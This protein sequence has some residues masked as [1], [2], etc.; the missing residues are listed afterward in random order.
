MAI[1]DNILGGGG[2]N[3]GGNSDNSSSTNSHDLNTTFGTDP[4]A[5]LNTSNVLHSD[6]QDGGH[7]GGSDDF[8][9]IGNLGVG[10]SAPTV[11]GV[12][13]SNDSSDTS[14]SHDNGGLLGGI[15]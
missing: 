15:G 12:S 13:S 7:N 5:G 2:N 10:L 8:T 4:Q 14:H 1:L 3:G 6:S 11:V 9:G